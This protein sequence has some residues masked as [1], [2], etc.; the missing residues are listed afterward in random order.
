MAIKIGHAKKSN[1]I[2]F[3]R[4]L[5]SE[6]MFLGY[7]LDYTDSSVC[8]ECSACCPS[9]AS[10]FHR[11]SLDCIGGVSH[12]RCGVFQ[13]CVCIA[14]ISQDPIAGLH[15]LGGRILRCFDQEKP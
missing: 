9:I 12:V 10:E 7:V 4:C 14:M 5:E 13:L 6:R 1:Y 3:M 15:R 8:L 11:S 2:N